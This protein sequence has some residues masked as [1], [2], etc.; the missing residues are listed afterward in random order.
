M[1]FL[2]R[3]SFWLWALP[4]LLVMLIM[5]VLGVAVSTNTGLDGLLALAQRLL[6]GQLSY[7]R[8][9]G[10][11]IG[12]LQLEKLRYTDGPLQ[13]AAERAELE[14]NPSALFNGLLKIDRLHVDGL[15]VRLPSGEQSPAPAEPFSLPDIQLPLAVQIADLQGR[16]L[17]ASE[18]T[19]CFKVD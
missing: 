2:R 12:P 4:L 19:N 11:L 5:L 6:P 14:W 15:D 17:D 13:I 10:R 18:S 3:W 16:F 1:R 9:E 8:I 7:Q